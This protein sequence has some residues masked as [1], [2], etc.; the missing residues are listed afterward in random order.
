M[1]SRQR[2]DLDAEKLSLYY[3]DTEDLLNH[4][5]N[6]ASNDSKLEKPVFIIHGI[7][8]AGKSSVLRIFRLFCKKNNI[9]VAL[10]NAEELKQTISFLNR[11]Y[12]DLK[13]DNV[14]LSAF[15]KNFKKYQ[16]TAQKI[17]KKIDLEARQQRN[18]SITELGGTGVEMLATLTPVAPLAGGLGT[19]SKVLSGYLLNFLPDYPEKEKDIDLYVKATEQLTNNFIDD[20]KQLRRKQRVVLILDTYEQIRELDDWVSYWVRELPPYVLV[21]I[22][23]RMTPNVMFEKP[24]WRNLRLR[25]QSQELEPMQEGDVQI[26]IRRYYQFLHGDDPTPEEITRIVDF[27]RGWPLAVT[28]AVDF[29]EYGRS[30]DPHQE[31][32]ALDTLVKRQG[33]PQELSSVI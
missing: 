29:W 8:G 15:E 26:L 31:P 25:I 23:G 7:G 16:D 14:N 13:R 10:A 3:T 5:Q 12:T 27:A 20:L 21:L 1:E 17:G 9:P 24:A 30:F 6:L 4:L 32:G 22:A 11:F 28:T 18:E 19:I 2:N 33:I